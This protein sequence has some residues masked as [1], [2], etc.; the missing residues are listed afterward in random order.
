MGAQTYREVQVVLGDREGQFS[1]DVSAALFTLGV[2]DLA[3]CHDA[4]ELRGSVTPVVDLVLCDVDLPGIDFG[5]VSQDIRHER[6]GGNPFMVLIAMARPS[7]EADLKRIIKS[8]VDAFLSRPMEAGDVMRQIGGFTKG[9]KPFVVT[10]GYVGPSRRDTRREDGSDDDLM[11]VPNT[12]RAKIIEGLRF[13]EIQRQLEEGRTDV[14]RKKAGASLRTMARLTQ[15]L[16]L[17]QAERAKADAVVRTLRQVAEKSDEIVNEH[18]GV[19]VTGHIAAIAARVGR[20]A[21]RAA[22]DPG[23]SHGVEIS[24]LAQLSDAAVGAYASATGSVDIAR[25][26]AAVVDGFL[27]RG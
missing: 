16:V 6:L 11:E 18:D 10:Q 1:R 20:L 14:K 13:A 15:R 12:L 27:A 2:R 25:E 5:V 7:S 3:I 19:S 17:Q 24:L 26:I 22:D 9:R 8:G 4:D 23:R 21:R